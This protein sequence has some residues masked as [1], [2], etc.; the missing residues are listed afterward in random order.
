[1]FKRLLYTVAM[2]F[3]IMPF[4]S[5]SRRAYPTS[6]TQKDSVVQEKYTERLVDT[7]IIIEKDSSLV[8]A[9][10]ECDSLNQVRIKEIISYK[11]GRNISPPV[12]T[13]KDNILT[14]TARTN[15]Q[16]LLLYYKDMYRE[17]ILK[18]SMTISR[19]V[20]VNILHWYQKVLMCLGGLFVM[21]VIILIIKLIKK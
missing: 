11:S 7:T 8:R 15:E 1:M 14:S 21:Y 13:I 10:L 3:V 17:A 16:K 6:V 2:A 18:Q 9:L 19:T 12:V 4:L 20:E 5:C